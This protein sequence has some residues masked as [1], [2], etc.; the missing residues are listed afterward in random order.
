VRLHSAI[1]YQ[2]PI[3]YEQKTAKDLAKI[4]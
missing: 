4:Q 2:S 3:C 1:G